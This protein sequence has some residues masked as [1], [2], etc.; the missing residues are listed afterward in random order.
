MS[1]SNKEAINKALLKNLN[2]HNNPPIKTNIRPK[3]KRTLQ[4]KTER[5]DIDIFNG[6]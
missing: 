4:S 1:I 2:G 6:N 5:R 3:Q